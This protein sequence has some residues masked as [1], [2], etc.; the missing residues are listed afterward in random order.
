MFDDFGWENLPPLLDGMLL[1][2]FLVVTSG[3]IGT[4]LGFILGLSRTAPSRTARILSSV[5]I[6]FI[7]GQPVLI[8]LFFVYFVLPL[9]FP[10][11]SVSRGLAA[12][13]GLSIYAAAYIAEI[14]RGSLLAV[15]SGQSEAAEAL[16]MNF[17]QKLRYVVLPQALRIAVPPGIGFLVALVKAT[18]LTSVI[19]YV[20]LTRA[21]RITSTINQ[22]PI[23]TFLI[24]GALYF[25][26]CYPIS[27]VGR[28]Y[29]RRLA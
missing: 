16:G 8:I 26:V 21:A 9:M 17:R 19:G 13:A 7:R 29:E 20:E 27:L 6:G 1:T 28:W 15:P 23:A 10:A 11:A 14:V 22:E 4:I 12:I 2:V 25:V 18:S 24:V 3:V 5:Y